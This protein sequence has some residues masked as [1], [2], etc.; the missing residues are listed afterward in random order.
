MKHGFSM[1]VRTRE[2]LE[3][4]PVFMAVAEARSFTAAAKRLG[5]S[6]SAASQAVRSLEA[7]IGAPLLNRSTRAISLTA[8]GEL[9]LADAG[10][11]FATLEQ[12]TRAAIGRASGPSGTLRLTMPKAGSVSSNVPRGV[13][14]G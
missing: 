11:A 10:A 3:G 4:L 6:P 7:R 12:A 8:A 14:V 5:V 9:F 1:V 13:R 2:L